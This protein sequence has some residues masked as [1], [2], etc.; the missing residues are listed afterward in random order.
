M[1]ADGGGGGCGF[2]GGLLCLAKDGASDNVQRISSI[3]D[4]L[5]LM[6]LLSARRI[7]FSA[8]F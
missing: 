3:F 5:S 7:F 8:E 2:G 4:I 6:A 1:I